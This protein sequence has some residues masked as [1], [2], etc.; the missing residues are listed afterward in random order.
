M[1]NMK[2]QEQKYATRRF[3]ILR[4]AENFKEKVKSNCEIKVYKDGKFGVR[5]KIDKSRPKPIRHFKDNY[6]PSD[7]DSE[8]NGCGTNWHTAEDL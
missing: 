1:N 5:F 8:I 6:D 3:N 4:S 2:N 7:F